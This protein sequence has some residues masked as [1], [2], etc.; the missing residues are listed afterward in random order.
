M[1]D[2]VPCLLQ[3]SLLVPSGSFVSSTCGYLRSVRILPFSISGLVWC[4]GFL[5]VLC[6]SSG[7]NKST[8]KEGRL[9]SDQSA[10]GKGRKHTVFSTNVLS[11]SEG[12]AA[13]T[14]TSL[15]VPTS[16]HS[17]LLREGNIN[18][19]G[20]RVDV[21]GREGEGG[22]TS[23]IR[24][25]GEDASFSVNKMVASFSAIILIAKAWIKDNWLL[26]LYEGKKR[27]IHFLRRLLSS[28]LE[29]IEKAES[30][31][32]ISCRTFS[33]KF[34]RS[35]SNWKSKHNSREI[36]NILRRPMQR[37]MKQYDREY[38]KTAMLKQEEMFRYQVR[39][40]HRL[41]KIQ[42]HLMSELK[43]A[44]ITKQRN[45]EIW[46]IKNDTCTNQPCYSSSN[47]RQPRPVLDLKLPAAEYIGQHS[48]E[49]VLNADEDSDLELKLSTGSSG[50]GAKKD[51]SGKPFTS[52]SGS[53]FSSSSNESGS[54]KQNSND[55]TL[56]QVPDVSTRL[57]SDRNLAFGFGEQMTKDGLKQPTWLFQ[58][59]KQDMVVSFG[60]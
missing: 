39:E 36:N 43:N 9:S 32:Q 14:A 8:A 50:A 4:C 2:F 26:K 11:S 19:D 18:L 57:R 47:Q 49:D 10:K 22:P 17:T 42:K 56:F 27:R 35:L 28:I 44:E 45:I 15:N 40:L 29:L 55:W 5:S 12:E 41:Y 53:S 59:S 48:G 54:M 1:S 38:M 60:L 33:A 46:N 51:M 20:S 21:A 31:I 37:D 13:T 52:D 25:V 24:W 7:M 6:L 23:A 16:S 58:C 34:G 30:R 3:F